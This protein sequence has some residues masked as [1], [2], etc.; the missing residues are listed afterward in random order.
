MVGLV[1][2]VSSVGDSMVADALAFLRVAGFFRVG[3]CFRFFA[4]VEDVVDRLCVAAF[5]VR[6]FADESLFA[7]SAIS[8][9]IDGGVTGDRVRLCLRHTNADKAGPLKKRIQMP[10]LCKRFNPRPLAAFAAAA[11]ERGCQPGT[12]IRW[13]NDDARE[14]DQ[15]RVEYSK[16]HTGPLARQTEVPIALAQRQCRR[17]ENANAN[18]FAIVP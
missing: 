1:S 7:M 10:H 16:L 5:F 4:V 2:A 3:V 11:D 6:F 9:P 15:F 14:C 8:I 18:W 13:M 12:A 17:S